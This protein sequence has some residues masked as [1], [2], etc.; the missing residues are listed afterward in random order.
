MPFLKT[1]PILDIQISD[2][3]FPRVGVGSG[4]MVSSPQDSFV[5]LPDQRKKG[6]IGGFDEPL[7]TDN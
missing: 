2:Q 7:A 1:H 4:R 5:I 6:R 3:N